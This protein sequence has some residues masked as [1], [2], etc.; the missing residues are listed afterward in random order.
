[1]NSLSRIL[2]NKRGT[3]SYSLRIVILSGLAALTSGVSGS[4]KFGPDCKRVSGT[5]DPSPETGP[6]DGPIQGGSVRDTA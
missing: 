2:R 1:M 4:P 5:V 3:L 6:R